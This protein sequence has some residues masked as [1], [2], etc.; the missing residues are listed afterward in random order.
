MIDY[1]SIA[2]YD[3]DFNIESKINALK[4]FK[5]HTGSIEILLDRSLVRVFFPI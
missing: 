2:N 4:F 3:I 1:E 5:F